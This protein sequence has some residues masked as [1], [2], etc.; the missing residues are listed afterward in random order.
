[1]IDQQIL[2]L[3]LAIAGARAVDARADQG[4]AV[5]EVEIGGVE[6]GDGAEFL[7]VLAGEKVE[8]ALAALDGVG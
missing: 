3:G 8:H 1:M 4:V 7:D 2:G 5:A 6:L